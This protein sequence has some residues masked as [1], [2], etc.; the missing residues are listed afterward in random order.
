[1]LEEFGGGRLGI[2]KLYA[3]L[4]SCSKIGRQEEGAPSTLT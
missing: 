4:L 1:M 3:W 2:W